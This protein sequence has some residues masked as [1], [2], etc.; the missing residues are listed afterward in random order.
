MLKCLVYVE[1]KSDES[2]PR[3]QNKVTKEVVEIRDE[4]EEKRDG[5]MKICGGR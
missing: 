5:G 2:R 4:A 3:K 1:I